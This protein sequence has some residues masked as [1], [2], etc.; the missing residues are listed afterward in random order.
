LIVFKQYRDALRHYLTTSDL[1]LGDCSHF[2]WRSPWSFLDWT[3]ETLYWLDVVYNLYSSLS[4]MCKVV[5]YVIVLT[6]SIGHSKQW[7]TLAGWRCL[8]G[9]VLAG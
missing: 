8:H 6:G 7:E 3:I 2:H 9:K 1:P 5:L 4:V